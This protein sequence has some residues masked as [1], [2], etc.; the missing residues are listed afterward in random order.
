MT[1]PEDWIQNVALPEVPATLD[2]RV[3][4]ML[5]S[6]AQRRPAFPLLPVPLW[7][8]AVLV[9]LAYVA[10]A[11]CAPAPAAPTATSLVWVSDSNP[12]FE[13]IF[14]PNRRKTSFTLRPW[15]LVN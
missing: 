11:W 1:P 5:T 9:A 15:I 8:C 2:R 10:G 14:L 12:T 6:G 13:R 3:A 4:T 7:A